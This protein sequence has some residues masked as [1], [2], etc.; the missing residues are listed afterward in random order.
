[1]KNE[2]SF[3]SEYK[4]SLL[5]RIKSNTVRCNAELGKYKKGR[6]YHA[7]SPGGKPWGIKI[8]VV[9][10]KNMSFDEFLIVYKTVGVKLKIDAKEAFKYLGGKI[11]KE[12]HRTPK[13]TKGD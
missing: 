9:D 6:L 13:K 7:T 5:K 1:M 3:P 12:V 4:L 8:K 10:V 11:K 2:I